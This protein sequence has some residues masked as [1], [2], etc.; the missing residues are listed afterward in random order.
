MVDGI[1]FNGKVGHI[2]DIKGTN[3]A[4]IE[5]EQ[6][7]VGAFGFGFKSTGIGFERNV[8][9]A[10]LLA[11]FE[12]LEVPKYTKDIAQLTIADKDFIPDKNLEDKA[13]CEV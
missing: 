3:A 2:E 1:N 5:A 10:D 11:K 9:P 12:N 8:V 7:K 13:F 4:R 6:P